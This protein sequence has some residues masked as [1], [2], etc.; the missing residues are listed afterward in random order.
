MGVAVD[1]V[2]DVDDLIDEEFVALVHT[3]VI[4]AVVMLLASEVLI[5]LFVDVFVDALVVIFVVGV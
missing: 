1:E 2:V 5:T 4:S 3:L